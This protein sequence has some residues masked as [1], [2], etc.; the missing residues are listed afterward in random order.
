[1]QT[2]SVQEKIANQEPVYVCL[3][4]NWMEAPV[5]SITLLYGVSLSDMYTVW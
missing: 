2:V 5:L 1:M 3:L 4:Q